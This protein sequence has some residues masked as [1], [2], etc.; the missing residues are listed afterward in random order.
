MGSA[1]AVEEA[2][3]YDWF[4]FIA[5]AFIVRAFRAR[6]VVPCNDVLAPEVARLP[7]VREVAAMDRG[8]SGGRRIVA[9]RLVAVGLV[10]ASIDVG[11]LL[12]AALRKHAGLRVEKRLFV[13]RCLA[14]R[15]VTRRLMRVGLRVVTACQVRG[16]VARKVVA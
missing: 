14:A 10:V 3:V 6:M 4:A 11:A 7:A 5:V 16:L 9:G 2:A 8:A 12:V 13:A 15:R 1:A